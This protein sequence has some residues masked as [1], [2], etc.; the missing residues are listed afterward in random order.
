LHI[1]I[2]ICSDHRDVVAV[3]DLVQLLIWGLQV[4][5]F[6][7]YSESEKYYNVIFPQR[8]RYSITTAMQKGKQSLPAAAATSNI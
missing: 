2:A 7:K 4:C 8:I 6:L 1:A 3:Q 5:V